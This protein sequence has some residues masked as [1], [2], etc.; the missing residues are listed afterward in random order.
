LRNSTVGTDG[1]HLRLHG[2]GGTVLDEVNYQSTGPWPTLTERGGPSIALAQNAL[3]P[4]AND[5]PNNWFASLRGVAGARNNAPTVV[6]N[7]L[8]TGSPGGVPVSV[9]AATVLQDVRSGGVNRPSS[10]ALDELPARSGLPGHRMTL[11]CAALPARFADSLDRMLALYIDHL[12]PK[13][14]LSCDELRR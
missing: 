7:R 9:A 11:S 12:F 10:L 3:D 13:G 4:T 6:F 5:N 1:E 2:N 14:G 8:D